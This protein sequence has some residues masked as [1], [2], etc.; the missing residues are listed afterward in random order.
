[1]NSRPMPTSSKISFL[2]GATPTR[3]IHRF[4]RNDTQ[5]MHLAFAYVA[6]RY[7]IFTNVTTDSLFTST[8]RRHW[9][10]RCIY[11]GRPWESFVSGRLPEKRKNPSGWRLSIPVTVKGLDQLEPPRLELEY[12]NFQKGVEIYR[13]K[14][15]ER[16]Y[17]LSPI[18]ENYRRATSEISQMIILMFWSHQKLSD[19]KS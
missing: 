6:S 15:I 4:R 3:C 10:S 13:L 7:F 18:F 16:P 9:P 1:M 19:H 12:A 5:E 8:L 11:N 14:S 17:Q 2:L